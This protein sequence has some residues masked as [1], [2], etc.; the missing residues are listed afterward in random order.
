MGLHKRVIENMKIQLSNTLI[1]QLSF[2][3]V[4]VIHN[5]CKFVNSKE[6]FLMAGE[7]FTRYYFCFH[8]SLHIISTVPQPV[9]SSLNYLQTLCI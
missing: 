2:Y 9:L 3:S 4:S 7:E 1:H 8:N 5:E 6:Y